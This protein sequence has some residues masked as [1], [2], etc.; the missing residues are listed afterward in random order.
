ML[1]WP[2]LSVPNGYAGEGLPLGLQIVGRAWDEAKIIGYAYAYEQAT[3][4]RR[5][6][7]GVPA[8]AESL[9]NEFIGTWGLLAI[10]ERDAA[11]GIETPAARAA[12]SGQLIYSPNGRLSVQIVRTGREK[13]STVSA[14][15]FSSYF[16][17]WEVVP[18][19][20]CVLHYQE[21]NLNAAQVGQEA[22]RYYSFDSEGHLSLATPPRKRDNGQEISSVFV[23]KRL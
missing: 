12:D 6:P 3:R 8:L 14:D 5:P 11:T 15:G 1:Q 4:Y 17:R 2:A 20:G 19:E 13:T 10:R 23:W 7:A 16:G 22:K 21:G 9:T 18:A